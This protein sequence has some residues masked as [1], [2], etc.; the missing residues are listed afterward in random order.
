MQPHPPQLPMDDVATTAGP[1]NCKRPALLLLAFVVML[2]AI[3]ALLL[4][5]KQVSG[6]NAPAPTEHSR[7][8][9]GYSD[10]KQ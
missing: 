8:A 9:P 1:K 6:R 5:K 3:A 10:P 2:L 7:Q 4:P